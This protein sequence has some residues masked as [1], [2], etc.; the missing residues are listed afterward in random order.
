MHELAKTKPAYQK[1]SVV[2]EFQLSVFD[3]FI[4]KGF[5]KELYSHILAHT[6]Y[7]LSHNKELLDSVKNVAEKV[8]R[9]YLSDTEVTQLNAAQELM[10]FRT[11]FKKYIAD[12]LDSLEEFFY[13][14]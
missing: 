6:F 4:G 12:N 9:D 13:N 3:E 14:I 8:L 7:E 5:K 1:H 11:K 2:V 10:P